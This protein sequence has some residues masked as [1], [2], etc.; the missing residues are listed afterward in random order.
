MDVWKAPYVPRWQ[1]TGHIQD[2][3][4]KAVRSTGGGILYTKRNDFQCLQYVD[5][6]VNEIEE[7][8]RLSYQGYYRILEK[9]SGQTIDE[10][11][12]RQAVDALKQEVPIT[13]PR[14]P[15]TT[16]PSFQY[17]TH[18]Y[19]EYQRV[20]VRRES[21]PF[22]WDTVYYPSSSIPPPDLS[23]FP[24]PPPAQNIDPERKATR[25]DRTKEGQPT[26]AELRYTLPQRIPAFSSPAVE[27]LPGSASKTSTNTL[28][29]QQARDKLEQL[30]KKRDEAEKAK[31][32]T[33]ASDL[34]YYAIPDM[35]KRIEEMERGMQEDKKPD[36]DQPPAR[37]RPAEIETDG[38][39]SSDESAP[40][41]Y[42]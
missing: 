20:Q 29:L 31:N 27:V 14:A 23:S 33:V 39:G 36:A 26:R 16:P 8:V 18:P 24:P 2:F 25:V 13:E 22:N 11:G 3:F 38:S 12:W 21:P 34:T 30:I 1:N 15:Y 42:E 32:T 6:R 40:D 10:R 19:P 28:D 5:Q 4:L 41:L 37:S 9:L 17:W 35:R 7:L